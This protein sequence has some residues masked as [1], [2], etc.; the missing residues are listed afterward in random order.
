MEQNSYNDIDNEWMM[1]LSSQ[2]DILEFENESVENYKNT[3][4]KEDSQLEKT[5]VS[6][7]SV[8]STTPP[9]PSENPAKAVEPVKITQ[10][11]T[12]FELIISTKT[13]V[14][15]LNRPVDIFTVFWKI[16]IIDYWKP[17]KGVIKKQIKIVS[18]TKEELEEYKSK[19]VNLNYYQEHIIK[20]I[21]NPTSRSIKF[22]DER[23]I[24]VG[25]SKK[26]ITVQRNRVKNA[27]YNCMALIIRFRFNDIFKE[28]HVKIFNTGKMEIPGIVDYTMLEYVKI[29]ILEILQVNEA[30]NEKTVTTDDA[31]VTT[32]DAIVD[33][34]PDAC[35]EPF[36]FIENFKEEHVLVNSNFNC[37]YFINREKL[38]N[39]L[40]SPKYGLESSYDPCNYSGVKCCY[41]F[42][43]QLGLDKET[44]K[45]VII[46][47]DKQMKLSVLM[48]CKKYTE[49]SLMIFRTGSCII[50][51]NCSEKILRFIFEFIKTLLIEEYTNICFNT[52]IPQVKNKS[53]KLIKRNIITSTEA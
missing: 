6:V 18:K 26:D 17:E 25:M 41:Y 43:N 13:K 32:D 37:G 22:K 14:L 30:C 15:F 50:V 38:Y 31:T 8:L 20:Q 45:G 10:S 11:V 42:N 39:I 53:F 34:S 46:D 44:Q 12:P 5:D 9:S 47:E 16:P 36:C 7:G 52:D 49:V 35:V 29:M 51:G 24:T 2:T 21:D 4:Q 19:L 23:K 1:F 48:E 27:F 40:I 3:V 33:Q 28:I